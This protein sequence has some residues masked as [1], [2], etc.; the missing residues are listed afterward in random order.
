MRLCANENIS[1]DCVIRKKI[2]A[3]I[4]PA[5]DRQK[6]THDVLNALAHSSHH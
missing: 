3:R 6:S 1:E 5:E 2:D 4:G